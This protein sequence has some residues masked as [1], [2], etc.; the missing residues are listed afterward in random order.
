M[1]FKLFILVAFALGSFAVSAQQPV[2]EVISKLKQ[3]NEKI[4]T[5]SSH[6]KQT[7][8]LPIMD[9][10]IISEGSFY[11]D[12]NGKVCM[13]YT[14]PQGD[15]LLINGETV[16]IVTN[17]K[18]SQSKNRFSELKSLLIACFKG[19]LNQLGNCKFTLVDSKTSYIIVAEMNK[20]KS[21]G[22]PQKVILTYDRKDCSISE[23]KMEEANGNTTLYQLSSKKINQPIEEQ[24]FTTKKKK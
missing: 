8:T 11:F 17:G 13:D 22:L 5:I 19:D 18:Q 2:N 12:H 15:I 14:N 21:K 16:Q 7:K 4:S 23:M 20:E 3:E 6:F 1:K 9:E 10:P 24:V